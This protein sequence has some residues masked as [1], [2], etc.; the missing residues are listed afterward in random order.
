[1]VAQTTPATKAARQAALA[2]L[3]A[4][5]NYRSQAELVSTLGEQ[6][7]SV[8]QATLSRDL[9]ELGAVRSRNSAGETVYML[10]QHMNQD[11]EDPRGWVQAQT[12]RLQVLCKDLL[13]SA[14]GSANIAVL[15]TPPGAAQFLAS[16]IDQADIQEIL[17]TIAGDDSIMVI[18]RND[19]GGKE[20]AAMFLAFAG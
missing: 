11:V 18:S 12:Q 20:L 1:M 13:L 8:T 3:I 9:M 19:S 10:A 6:G 14:D 4:T 2:K 17:G 16:A 7:I 15:R 5:G